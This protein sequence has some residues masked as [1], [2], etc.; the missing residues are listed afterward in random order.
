MLNSH[1]IGEYGMV[2]RRRNTLFNEYDQSYIVKCDLIVVSILQYTISVQSQTTQNILEAQRCTYNRFNINPLAVENTTRQE[3]LLIN[4]CFPEVHM[5]DVF[6]G[7][8]LATVQK[9]TQTGYA[10]LA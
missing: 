4:T 5:C 8:D 3:R 6:L 10:F 9:L 1:I 7:E 2:E